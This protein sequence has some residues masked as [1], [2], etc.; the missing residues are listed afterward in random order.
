MCFKFLWDFCQ[1]YYVDIVLGY[2]SFDEIPWPKENGEE[3]SLFGS[4]IRVIVHQWRKSGQKLGDRYWCRGSWGELFP[5]FLRPLSSFQGY[6]LTNGLVPPPPTPHHWFR[7]CLQAYLQS[8]VMEAFFN[9]GFLP[10]D[11]HLC[12][13]TV[14]APSALVK[15]S[16]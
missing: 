13:V 12:Q 2:Y 14:Q 10:D 15:L 16:S 3:K 1:F 5:G 6:Q 11:C 9:W 7:K 4:Q 8:E